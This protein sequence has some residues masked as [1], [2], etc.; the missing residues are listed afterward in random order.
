MR[1]NEDPRARGLC[2]PLMVSTLD[3]GASGVHE[4]LSLSP[5]APIILGIYVLIKACFGRKFMND[6]YSGLFGSLGK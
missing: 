1:S 4:R 3:F 2:K 6:S 5:V